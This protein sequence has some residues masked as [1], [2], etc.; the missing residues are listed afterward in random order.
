MEIDIDILRYPKNWQD[1]RPSD[2][3]LLPPHAIFL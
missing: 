1:T 3:Y 2:L